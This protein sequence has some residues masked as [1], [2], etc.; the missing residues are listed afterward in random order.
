MKM[1]HFRA[2]VCRCACV[3]SWKSQRW[4]FTG[5]IN[6]NSQRF[7]WFHLFSGIPT[8]YC[9]PSSA[10]AQQQPLPTTTT[11]TTIQMVRMWRNV[12]PALATIPT[13][14]WIHHVT[15]SHGWCRLPSLC[16]SHLLALRAQTHIPSP[17]WPVDASID[18][19]VPDSLSASRL[20]SPHAHTVRAIRAEF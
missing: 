14:L 2:D 11:T 12:M 19:I 17:I 8:K 4:Y 6:N 16:C 9:A 15:L 1:Q 5:V 20:S 10:W 18:S 3:W 7:D 13:A